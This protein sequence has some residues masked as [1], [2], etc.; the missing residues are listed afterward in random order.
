MAV[1]E[2]EHTELPIPNGWFAVAWSKDLVAGDVQPIHYFGEDLVLFRT[3]SGQVR[4]LDAYCVHLGAHL[5]EGGRVM[6]DT[7]RCPFHG[8]QY[9]GSNGKC[10]E[11]P[12]CDRIPEGA[13]LRAWHVQEK[14]GLIFVWFHSED[15]PPEWD[16]PEIDE[17]G[18]PEWSVPRTFEFELPAHVQDTHEN[19][20]DPVHFHYVHGMV[21][22]PESEITFSEDGRNYRIVS[23]QE[24][25]QPPVPLLLQ[26]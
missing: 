2:R 23:H 5:G 7:I 14:N 24:Q 9:D 22:V 6:G 13:K 20:N 8:W 17:L 1:R 15:E 18:D 3:R 11:I 10:V 12:Y 26:V 4:V 21:G 25:R 16:F 19:N